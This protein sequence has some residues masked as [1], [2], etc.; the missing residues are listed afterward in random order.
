ME[1]RAI[2]YLVSLARVAKDNYQAALRTN[3]LQDVIK[4]ANLYHTAFDA[5]KVETKWSLTKLFAVVN[6]GKDY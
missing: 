1:R 3:D 4:K 2:D 6:E 5:L